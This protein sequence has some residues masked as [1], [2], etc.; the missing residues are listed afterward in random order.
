MKLNITR[1]NGTVNFTLNTKYFTHALLLLLILLTSFTVV[2]SLAPPPFFYD[3]AVT[4]FVT[5][6]LYRFILEST[7]KK[8]D[9]KE[10]RLPLSLQI[11]R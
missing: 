1:P 3:V 2:W 9:R 4:I 6:K 7:K 10:E 11:K 5:I 8:T